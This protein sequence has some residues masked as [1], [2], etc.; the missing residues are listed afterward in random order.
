MKERRNEGVCR[1]DGADVDG[2]HV[3]GAHVVDCDDVDGAQHVDGDDVDWVQHVDCAEHVVVDCV[4]DFCG[5]LVVDIVVVSVDGSCPLVFDNADV[6][7]VDHDHAHVDGDVDDV[8]DDNVHGVDDSNDIDDSGVFVGANDFVDCRQN[9]HPLF[10]HSF[11]SHHLVIDCYLRFLFEHHIHKQRVF[12]C[13]F[14]TF[15]L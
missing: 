9:V 15:F 3:D 6:I 5:V 1:H 11:T 10:L 4:G 13:F 12:S 8:N 7:V 14:E 2:E